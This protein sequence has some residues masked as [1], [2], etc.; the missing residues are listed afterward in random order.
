M[1]E[2]LP[3]LCKPHRVAGCLLCEAK[4]R[5]GEPDWPP[6]AQVRAAQLALMLAMGQRVNTR[7]VRSI[8]G[9]SVP[10]AK[11]D[12]ALLREAL[13]VVQLGGRSPALVLRTPAAAV[14]E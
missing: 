14:S 6:S 2:L 11:R 1:S 7:L 4:I 12:L 8:Y 9:V 13:P 5:V 3:K 10:T